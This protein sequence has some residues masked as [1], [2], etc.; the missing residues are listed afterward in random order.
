MHKVDKKQQDLMMAGADSSVGQN[1]RDQERLMKLKQKRVISEITATK[2]SDETNGR[3]DTTV[4][5]STSMM[6]SADTSREGAGS[7][8][9]D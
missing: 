3:Q 8:L 1:R 6:R 5:T 4:D 2:G 9:E 7:S